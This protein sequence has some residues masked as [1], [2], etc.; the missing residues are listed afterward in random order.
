MK[1]IPPLSCSIYY[2]IYIMKQMSGSKD[3]HYDSL[4]YSKYV[5]N[6]SYNHKSAH[7]RPNF[8]RYKTADTKPNNIFLSSQELNP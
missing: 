5:P 6:P 2:I 1:H 3:N 7:S 4:N 8:L